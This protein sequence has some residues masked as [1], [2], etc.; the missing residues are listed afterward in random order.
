MAHN[1]S[2]QRRSK[3]IDIHVHFFHHVFEEGKL[4][5]AKIDT[6]VNSIDILTKIVPKEKFEFAKTSLGPIKM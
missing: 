1:H 6:K 2:S 5:V 4:R 3:H